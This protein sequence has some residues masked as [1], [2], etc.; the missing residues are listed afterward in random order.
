MASEFRLKIQALRFT[1]KLASNVGLTVNHNEEGVKG[2]RV[3]METSHAKP[4][5]EEVKPGGL[6]VDPW[7]GHGRCRSIVRTISSLDTAHS[8]LMPT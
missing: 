8:L 6:R 5:P 1:V 2:S 7:R 3:I 4:I